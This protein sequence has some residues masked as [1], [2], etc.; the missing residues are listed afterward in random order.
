MCTRQFFRVMTFHAARAAVLHRALPLLYHA[1]RSPSQRLG[2]TQELANLATY[3]VSD[4]ASWMSGNVV[5]LDGGESV[6][7]SGEFNMLSSITEQ[8]WDQMEKLI[9]STKGS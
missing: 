8:Q 5:T 2:E 4:Y 1:D 7:L 6:A 3:L 9:R